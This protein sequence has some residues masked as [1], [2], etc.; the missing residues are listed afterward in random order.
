MWSLWQPANVDAF[1]ITFRVSKRWGVGYRGE[2][3]L[4]YW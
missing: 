1:P 3:E 4:I 2:S